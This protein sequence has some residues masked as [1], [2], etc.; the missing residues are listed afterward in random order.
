[1]ASKSR[2]KM[3]E[4]CRHCGQDVKPVVK[5]GWVSVLMWVV[6]WALASLAACL[7]AAMHTFSDATV[8][9]AAGIVLWPVAIARTGWAHP[10]AFAV[11]IAFVVFLAVGGAAGKANE[12]AERNARC[13]ECGL[14]LGEP[15]TA[16][17]S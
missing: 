7:V 2:A 11:L 9:G 12:A 10:H 17:A 3:V 5:D 14:R 8:H 16:D 4:H 15:Q 6:L 13:P 1:M